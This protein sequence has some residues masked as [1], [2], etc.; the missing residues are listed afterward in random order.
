[1]NIVLDHL[2]LRMLFL[3]CDSQALGEDD[4]TSS[5]TTVLALGEVI[6]LQLAAP[7]CM[8]ETDH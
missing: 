6:G 7:V 2:I 4:V 8:Q 1:M 3:F 5:F